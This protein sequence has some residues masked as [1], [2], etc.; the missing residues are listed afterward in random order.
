MAGKTNR[1]R[2]TEDELTGEKAAKA[3]KTEKPAKTP[4]SGG[5]ATDVLSEKAA[6]EAEKAADVLPKDAL[7]KRKVRVRGKPE[8]LNEETELPAERNVARGRKTS[9]KLHA[10][11]DAAKNSE[12]LRTETDDSK[13]AERMHA[14]TENPKGV[15]KLRGEAD[16]PKGRQKLRVET[17]A[18]KGREKLRTEA[19]ISKNYGKKLRFGKGEAAET[20]EPDFGGLRRPGAGRRVTRQGD[21]FN[22]EAVGAGWTEETSLDADAS[23]WS[24]AERM[25]TSS[26]R[27]GTG[28]GGTEKTGADSKTGSRSRRTTA[29][30]AAG[31]Q[32]SERADM[33]TSKT[34]GA[35]SADASKSSDALNSPISSSSRP[36]ASKASHAAYS[37]PH[38]P[39][40]ATSAAANRQQVHRYVDE[41]VGTQV[42]N[43]TEMAGEDGVRSVSHARYAS[44]LKQEEK[45]E[46][47]TQKADDANVE[48][49]YQKH[50]AENPETATNPLSR[51]MQKREIKKEY[52]AARAATMKAGGTGA[53]ASA[54]SAVETEKA[55]GLFAGVK[56]FFENNGGTMKVV[57]VVALVVVLLVTQLQSCGMMLSGVVSYVDVA[58]WPA[59]DDEISKAEAYYTKLEAQLQKKINQTEASHSG[60]DEYNYNIGE[61][62]H[63]ST[64]L[65]SYLSAKYGS[66]T[67]NEVKSELDAI[68]ALQYNL[69]TETGTETRTVTKTVQAGEY[70][71][72]VVTSG[73]C[74][75]SICCGQWAGSAT[76]SGVYP[77]ASHTIAVDASNPIV[78]I[79]TQIIMNGTLYTVE[80]TGN[81]ATYGVD[82]DVYY[83]DHSSALAHGHQTWEAYYAGGDG[84]EIEVT[85]TE[86]VDVCYVT[87]ETTSFESILA[88]RMSDEESEAYDV[89]MQT[90][91][92]RIFFGSPVDFNWHYYLSGEYGY[93][94]DGTRV[95]ESD[96]LDITV[97]S[98]TEVLSVMDG[99][100]KSV[101]NGKVKLTDENGS[102]VTLGGLSSIGVS[103]GDEVEMGETIAKVGSSGV[104]TVSFTYK[105]STLNPY[106]YLDT[107]EADLYADTGSVTGKAALLIAKAYQYLGVPYVWGGYSPSGFDCSGFVCYCL[108]NCGAGWN[109]GRL[110]ANG[111]LETCTVVS[112]SKA[113]PG[114]LI[115]FQ[116]TYN[117]AGAS[118][119][120]IYLGNG[121]MIH[122][123]SPV[124]ITSITSSYW[125]SHFYCFGRLS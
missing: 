57:L 62:S 115:F 87:V 25:G 32:G 97:P 56:G 60:S 111:L 13:G 48:A 23:E 66:F 4:K 7:S 95:T 33:R 67:F 11:R 31:S 61:I 50:L 34:S 71:G 125:Q 91:G 112:A 79:G 59:D 74:S 108:N 40:V 104:L 69:A 17:D 81:L 27:I 45:A 123:G 21:V 122:C 85:T 93:R 18:Q 20:G 76:A 78:P 49:L 68:F 41:N 36:G 54:A 5:K 92:G 9:A 124:S 86:T 43:Q 53:A 39:T 46:K 42:V 35:I 118:H 64:A 51:W 28:R 72:E 90:Y 70:I 114:D 14:E 63:D 16:A 10:E 89:Y 101:S 30:N 116:G 80:D 65:I 1:L 44:K 105:G 58:T 119:V 113:Q 96:S 106:F 77:T 3:V 24:G 107:G 99:K 19:D 47:L 29:A 55:G 8:T 37:A 22:S 102:V 88:G 12:K 73:Y 109:Y 103:A 121:Q 94:C 82:F 75:C 15:E 117:T 83:G 98:G 2:F 120:G 110:T 52:E 100:V 26:E 38:V 84:E 6:D